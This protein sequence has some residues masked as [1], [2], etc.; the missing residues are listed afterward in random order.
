MALDETPGEIL[1]RTRDGIRDQYTQDYS[2]RVPEADVGPGTQPYVDASVAADALVLV[3]N[4]AVVIGRGT[5]TR[6]S[7][8]TWLKDI[9]ESEGIFLR[10]AVGAVGY[11]E[12]AA[13][14]GGGTILFGTELKDKASGLRFKT[15]APT[16]LYQDGAELAVAGIDTGPA[17]NLKA[18]TILEFTSQ[19]PGI[20]QTATVVLQAD[21]SGLSGG[22]DADTDELYR[23]QIEERRANPPASGNDAE[24][25]RLIE[26]TKGHGVSV[27]K[28]FTYPGIF[29]PGT[30][31]FTFT[32]RATT[33][34]GSRLPNAAELATVYAYVVGKEPGDD[35]LFA[36]SLL[37]DPVV[38]ALQVEWKTGAQSWTDVTPW[39][40]Y[41][42]GDKVLVDGAT[43]PTATAFRLTTGTL[44]ATPQVG[45]TIAFFDASQGK[46]QPK[47]IGAVS[48]VVAGKSW[49]ITCATSNG[50]SDVTYTPAVG[51]APSPYSLSLDDLVAPVRGYMAGLGPG[52]Q[53]SPLPDPGRRQRRQ[54]ESPAV[55]PSVINNR[56]LKPLFDV[57]SVSDPKLLE[58]TAP[59]ATTVGTP[60]VASYL[61]TLGDFCAFP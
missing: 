29:G 24:Y 37:A 49:D 43:T 31:G 30:I 8:G 3:H 35:S 34:G 9:G 10:P 57:A 13:L 45:Q 4:D 16:G 2:L 11:V 58:P 40:T 20:G 23:L 44:T 53:V 18:G 15:I 28:A 14:S 5:N 17:T 19:P 39:P 32:V 33:A 48:V 51:Q 52:E 26:D 42:A 61:L 21:G 1:T 55:W 27:E 7:G 6:T 25:Q 38:V 41:I 54:P 56:L 47:R 12:I 36:C 22:R 50:A 59:A 46:L 60:G